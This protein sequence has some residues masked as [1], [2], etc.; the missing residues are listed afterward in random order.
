[1]WK[2]LLSKAAPLNRPLGLLLL[3]G[4]FALLTGFS[5]AAILLFRRYALHQLVWASQDVVWMA[6]VAYGYY[7][8]V[9]AITLTGLALLV[10]RL[11]T[12]RVAVFVFAFFAVG[13]LSLLLLGAGIHMIAHALL[14][15][16]V[17]LQLSGQA[18]RRAQAFTRL[19]LRTAPV[20]AGVLL[21]LM[22]GMP[23]GR[24]AAARLALW[25]L[26]EATTGAP[27]VLLI[28]WDTVRERN[29]SL[30]GY[31]RPTT[32]R[33]EQ[34]ASRGT[35]FERAYAPAPWTLG[36]H[37]SIFTGRPLQDM[38]AN[39]RTPLS[40]SPLTLAERLRERG[41]ST[42][43]FVANLIAATRE[44]GLGRGFIRYD[45]FVTAPNTVLLNS[46]VGQRVRKQ[47][48]GTRM[49]L[50]P[51]KDATRITDDFL[52]WL[53]GVGDRPFFAFLN[54]FDA[55][56]PYSPD[57]DIYA[58]FRADRPKRDRYDAAI[59]TLDL[60]LDRLLGE[61]DRR[62]VLDNTI[63]ILT[64]DHGETFGEKGLWQH[65]HSLYAPLL[66]VPLVIWR[67]DGVGAGQ[68]VAR[69]VSLRDLGSTVLELTLGRDAPAFPGRSLA[70]VWTG[71]GST[72]DTLL[73][74]VP[75]GIN[76]PPQ[77]PV[78]RGNMSSVL[79]HNLHYIL[80]GDGVE[81]LYDLSKDPAENVNLAKSPDYQRETA[82]LRA[83]L[84]RRVDRRWWKQLA[85]ARDRQLRLALLKD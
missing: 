74:G 78:T 45:D 80:N 30:Y 64:A 15:A 75:Q 35:V 61:L 57:W 51:L 29:L 6:P 67:P 50:F 8:L 58:R 18:E 9:L 83:V 21:L 68:N 12:L 23:A 69:A 36:T 82:N 49:R 10:P 77:E 42:A 38:S 79:V 25:R 53:P 55:H 33:L 41:Y 65:G 71:N 3:F 28:I 84:E 5:E 17:A 44:T 43:G 85:A 27:N 66:H 31:E 48:S 7:G 24:A 40:G 32:P 46:L 81:E 1:M 63:V 20:L 22:I 37:A 73:A 52:E 11:V 4:W 16:G 2:R 19:V 47:S 76:T 62:G 72:R 54:Y 34:W 60:Q 13:V 59:A 56:D 70:A 14:A 26:P 39:W